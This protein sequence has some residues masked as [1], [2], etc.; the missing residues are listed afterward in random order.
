MHLLLNRAVSQV[1]ATT[2]TVII[3]SADF[4]QQLLCVQELA[5]VL[6]DTLLCRALIPQT[7][8]ALYHLMTVSTPKWVWRL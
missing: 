8:Q 7:K 4:L 5:F 1:E 6:T 3:T 2:V